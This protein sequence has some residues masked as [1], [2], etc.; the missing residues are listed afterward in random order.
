MWRGVARADTH[1]AGFRKGVITSEAGTTTAAYLC[2][3]PC[4]RQT[5]AQSHIMNLGC[6]IQDEDEQTGCGQAQRQRSVAVIQICAHGV[7]NRGNVEQLQLPFACVE[8]K[9]ILSRSRLGGDGHATMLVA[10]R[11]GIQHAVRSKM[12]F[13]KVC[14][15]FF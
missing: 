3:V 15:I 1:R 12:V 5:V 9:G 6:N 14:W 8:E 7:Q 2:H 13:I 11:K 10:P 4:F